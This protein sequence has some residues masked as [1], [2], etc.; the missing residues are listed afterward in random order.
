MTD[1]AVSPARATRARPD[2]RSRLIGIATAVVLAAAVWV[3]ARP[4]LGAEMVVEDA[5]GKEM[6]IGIAPVLIMSTA[7]SLLGWAFLA[8]LERFTKHARIIWTILA[9]ILLVI[10]FAP[11]AGPMSGGTRATLAL[12]HLSVGIPLIVAF[13]RS[14][15]AR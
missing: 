2:R 3:I 8:I 6:E 1:T 13:W 5:T 4:V 7:A 11:L 15:P 12:L 14:A 10:T 9:G